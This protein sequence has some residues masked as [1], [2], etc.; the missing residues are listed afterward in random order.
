MTTCRNR[1]HLLLSTVALASVALAAVVQTPQPGADTPA[2]SIRV[3]THMLLVDVVITDKQGKP[4]PG[5]HAE[6]FVVEENGKTQKI[7]SL[8]TPAENAP[9]AATQ[10][11][12]GIYSNRPQYRSTGGPITV[13][14]LDALNTAFSDQAYARGQMLRFVQEQYKPGQGMAV[15]TLTGPL[16]E[17]QD[18]TGD[19]QIL[20]AALQSY[21][22]LEQEFTPNPARTMDNGNGVGKGR[23]LQCASVV[24]HGWKVELIGYIVLKRIACTCVHDAQE[25]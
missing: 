12:P 1:L 7:S 11:P 25:N 4:V 15:F 16:N 6:D 22:P 10:L 13:M 14:L 20:Y 2:P 18:F 9:H 21:K 5:L 23:R 8:V 17:L 3:T 24:R 19:P